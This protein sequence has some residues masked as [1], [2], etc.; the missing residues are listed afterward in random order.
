MNKV[1]INDFIFIKKINM[2]DFIYVKKRTKIGIGK[3]K[4]IKILC[5]FN[6]IK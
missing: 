1:R 5:S 4:K 3:K 6:G 2:I